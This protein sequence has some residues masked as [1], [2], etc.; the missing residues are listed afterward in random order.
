LNPG[1]CNFDDGIITSGDGLRGAMGYSDNSRR[2]PDLFERLGHELV[3]RLLANLP[4]SPA[5]EMFAKK[6]L[7]LALYLIENRPTPER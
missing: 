2:P 4:P 6:S 1:A 3:R 5:K 7:D